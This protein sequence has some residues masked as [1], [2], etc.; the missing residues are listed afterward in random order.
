MF[1]SHLFPRLEGTPVIKGK[2]T[3]N[4]V[5]FTSLGDFPPSGAGDLDE[6][7]VYPH[8]PLFFFLTH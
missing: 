3:V 8:T 4:K 7:P 5:A 6:F 2:A 1:K